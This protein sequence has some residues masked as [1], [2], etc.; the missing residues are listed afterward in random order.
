MQWTHNDTFAL[1]APH[2]V[3]CQGLGLCTSPRGIV[4]PCNCVLR[5]IFR[6]C[7]ARFRHCA[8]KEKRMSRTSLQLTGKVRKNTWGR[9]DEEYVADFC[10]VSR[11]SLTESEHRIF[12]YHYLLGADWRL[13]CRKL[14][15]DRGTFFHTIYRIQAKLGRAYREL[16]PYSLFPLDEYFLD[17]VRGRAAQPVAA[18]TRR[19]QPRPVAPPRR[20]A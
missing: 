20:A 1:S 11:R 2:C 17:V 8:E 12:R 5:A 13:C 3:K 6:A 18:L 9:K 4:F 15:M 10:L 14:G 16:E 19:W 7:Y